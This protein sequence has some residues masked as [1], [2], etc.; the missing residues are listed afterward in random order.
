LRIIGAGRCESID[1]QLH[2]RLGLAQ[3]ASLKVDESS[4]R[5]TLQAIG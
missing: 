1:G 5:T 4:S 3:G 2:L